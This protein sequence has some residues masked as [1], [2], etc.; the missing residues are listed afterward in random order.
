MWERYH[1][2]GVLLHVVS[3]GNDVGGGVVVGHPCRGLVDFQL[4]SQLVPVR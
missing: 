2:A 3:E 4:L 1:G